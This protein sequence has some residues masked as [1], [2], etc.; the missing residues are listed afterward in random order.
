MVDDTPHRPVPR[1]VPTQGHVEDHGEASDY[2]G[3]YDHTN[4]VPSAIIARER[5][6]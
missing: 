1:G 6:Q 4:L 5:A 3:L 2:L